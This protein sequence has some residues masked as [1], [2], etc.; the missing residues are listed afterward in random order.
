MPIVQNLVLFDTTEI[1]ENKKYQV[2]EKNN[3]TA[4]ICMY[5]NIKTCI[6]KILSGNIINL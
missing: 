3:D 2:C 4:K 5:I 1:I 6:V